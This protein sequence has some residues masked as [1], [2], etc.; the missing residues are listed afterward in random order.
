MS[1]AIKLAKLAREEGNFPFGAVVVRNGNIIGR[2]RCLEIIEED[3]TKHAELIAVGEAC[4]VVGS[5]NLSNCVLYAS[6]EP[7]NM[8]ASAAFQAD[9]GKVVIGIKRDDLPGFFRK[10]SIGIQELAQDSSHEIEIIS[11]ILKDQAI[12]LFEGVNR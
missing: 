7:C 11:G 10:R 3:V 5:R 4:R 9:I 8:C 12:K 6:G 1:E 2:G